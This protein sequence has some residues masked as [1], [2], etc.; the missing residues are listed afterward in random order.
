MS[1]LS[2]SSLGSDYPG[3]IPAIGI[4]VPEIARG[5]LQL[6]S[7]LMLSTLIIGQCYESQN[8]PGCEPLQRL[9]YEQHDEAVA[10]SYV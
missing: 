5:V 10:T 6:Q 9:S 4:A 7:S 1:A 8:T 3:R 2:L